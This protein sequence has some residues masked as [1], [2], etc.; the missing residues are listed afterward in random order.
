MAAVM[1]ALPQK[2]WDL[3]QYKGQIVT[4]K[5]RRPMKMRKGRDMIEKEST[6]QC[7]IGV[8]YD[9][10]QDV[11]Y[12]R[13]TGELPAY[14]Q[15]LPWGQWVF[16]PYL[17]EYKDT[18][19]FRCTVLN[20]PKSIHK[21]RYIRGGV[22]ITKAEAMLDCLASEFPLI[23]TDNDVFNIKVDN[24]LEVNGQSV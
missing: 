10:I 15:G 16:F 2:V 23:Q 19:Y 1:Q 6:F 4:L 21:T 9:N 17:L 5:T 14:N 20:N 7:R 22:D 3:L 13:A 24:I 12:K 8:N 18:Y 11:K